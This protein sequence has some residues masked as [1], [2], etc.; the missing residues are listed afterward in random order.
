MKIKKEYFLEP[1]N[2]NFT[3]KP[4][5]KT[6]YLNEV[7]LFLWDVLYENDCSNAELLNHVLEKFDIS[8]VLALGEIDSFIKLLKENGIIEK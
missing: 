1:N 4:L 2:D 7:G 8:T 3:I 6:L 5:N